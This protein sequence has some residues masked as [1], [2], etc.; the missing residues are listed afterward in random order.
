MRIVQLVDLPV[1]PYAEVWKKQHEIFDQLLASEEADTLI[2]CEHPPVYTLGRVTDTTNIL[3]SDA[4]LERIGAEKFEIERGGDVTY[5]GPG[6]LVGYPLLNLTHFKEDLGWYLR[7]L[8]E[9]V[10]RVLGSYDITA[11]RVDGRTGV[12]VHGQSGD[13]KICAIGVKASRWCTMHGFAFNINTDLSYFQYIVPCGIGD[14]KVTSLSLLLGQEV[15]MFDIKQRYVD[16]FEDIFRVKIAAPRL[17][18]VAP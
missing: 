5:H 8:E 6:Q 1:T 17:Q 3:F 18:S 12:W 4:E 11:F 13:E 16:S 7:S 14:K 15:N 2:L 9:T 10:I